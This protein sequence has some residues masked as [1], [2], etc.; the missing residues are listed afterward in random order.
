[1]RIA[2][3]RALTQVFDFNSSE[4][5]I[6]GRNE[7]CPIEG[8]DTLPRVFCSISLILVEMRIA[9]LRAQ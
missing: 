8:I 6:C 2:R 1:M 7:D 3:L 9:R 5:S 4:G